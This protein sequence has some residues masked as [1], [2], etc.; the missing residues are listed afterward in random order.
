MLRCLG[1]AAAFSV[2][3]LFTPPVLQIAVQRLSASRISF[4]YLAA[5]SH[6]AEPQSTDLTQTL[7]TPFCL[8]LLVAPLASLAKLLYLEKKK[9]Q[10]ILQFINIFICDIL[11]FCSATEVSNNIDCINKYLEK[12]E[13]ILNAILRT[14]SLLIQ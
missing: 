9:I 2:E 6:H 7:V 12:L 10:N 3:A 8:A 11:L 14:Q 5:H 13:I 4:L 1:T